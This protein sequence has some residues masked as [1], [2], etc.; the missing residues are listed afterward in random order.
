MS[1]VPVSRTWWTPLG[2]G[3]V[4][5]AVFVVLITLSATL[6]QY[7]PFLL[8]SAVAAAIPFLLRSPAAQR[9][10]LPVA[11]T[12]QAVAHPPAAGVARALQR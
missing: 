3:L 6:R 12:G 9:R 10:P 4:V 2:V 8:L 11:G 7:W 1:S 5:V